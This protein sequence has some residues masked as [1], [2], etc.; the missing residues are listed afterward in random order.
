MK[1]TIRDTEW[2][3]I[4][5]SNSQM[6]T[7][8]RPINDKSA[9]LSDGN[10]IA[11]WSTGTNSEAGSCPSVCA[12]GSL[13]SSMLSPINGRYIQSAKCC[14]EAEI[15]QRASTSPA[16]RQTRGG[17][18]VRS[19]LRRFVYTEALLPERSLAPTQRFQQLRNVNAKC[20]RERLEGGKS[21]IMAAPLDITHVR[22]AQARL[23]S[24]LVLRPHRRLPESANVRAQDFQ[25]FS[26]RLS[27][28]PPRPW[29]AFLAL[30]YRDPRPVSVCHLIASGVTNIPC[31]RLPQQH[32]AQPEICGHE[33]MVP[34]PKWHRTLDAAI[35]MGART[36]GPVRLLGV[37]SNQHG[38]G[39]ASRHRSQTSS[40]QVTKPSRYSRRRHG[41]QTQPL[42]RDTMRAVQCGSKVHTTVRQWMRQYPVLT[43]VEAMI[44]YSASLVHFLVSERRLTRRDGIAYSREFTALAT[45]GRAPVLRINRSKGDRGRPSSRKNRRPAS[46][47]A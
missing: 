34:R 17:H 30:C 26:P 12:A 46:G 5:H 15:W 2:H 3:I 4:A 33:I 37:I 27:V 35:T 23:V 36:L 40:D 42:D 31:N 18:T 9:R 7:G 47:N 39:M 45:T 25:R 41:L 10:A 8:C 14:E 43:V 29:S 11:N 28:K 16:K 24:Q 19:R 21:R 38:D 22:T 32:S 6:L 1:L 44:A 20:I 13:K